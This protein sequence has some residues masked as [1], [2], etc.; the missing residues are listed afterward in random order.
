MI[1]LLSLSPLFSRSCVKGRR[2]GREVLDMFSRLLIRGC[3][4]CTYSPPSVPCF[5]P[6]V[7]VSMLSIFLAHDILSVIC[8][9]YMWCVADASTHPLKTFTLHGLGDFRSVV[10]L[11]PTSPI[12]SMRYSF[13]SIWPRIRAWRSR[14]RGVSAE[15]LT[16]RDS[17]AVNCTRGSSSPHKHVACMDTVL[18]VSLQT[19]SFS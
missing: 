10:T 13:T 9:T 14:A 12:C 3:L 17:Y 7:L 15:L 5:F 6:P 11:R 19:Y 2:A 8:R 16:T 1:V 18:I 4:C